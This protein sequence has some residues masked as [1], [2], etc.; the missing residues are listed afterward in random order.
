MAYT[1][2]VAETGAVP[3]G[4][5][6]SRGGHDQLAE[7]VVDGVLLHVERVLAR[8]CLEPGSQ[9][10]GLG[11]LA[12]AAESHAI[13]AALLPLAAASDSRLHFALQ[14]FLNS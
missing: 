8:D 4:I 14:L 3:A 7:L 6:V 12:P 9:P 2:A 1:V 10:L 5:I 11:T 13:A